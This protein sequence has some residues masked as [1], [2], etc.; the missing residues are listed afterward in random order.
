M[1]KYKSES[2]LRSLIKGISWRIVAT[3]DTILVVLIVTCILGNC[4]IDSAI[5]IGVSEFLIKYITYYIHERLWQPALENGILSPRKTLYKSI[6]W[7]LIATTMTFIISGTVLNAFDEV[8]LYIAITELFTK[9]A[10]YYFHERLWLKLPLGKIRN[11][12]FKKEN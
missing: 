4:S 1:G 3:S 12:F 2:H 5:K 6:S 8:A 11:I 10:L 9:F 7:R